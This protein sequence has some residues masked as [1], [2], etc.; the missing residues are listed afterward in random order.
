MTII[1]T[2]A[3]FYEMLAEAEQSSPQACAVSSFETV[4][5]Y[6]E[7]LGSGYCRRIEL[8]NG[9]LLEIF[10]YQL[11][12]DLIHQM[13]E[14]EHPWVEYGVQLSGHEHSEYGAGTEAGQ[15]VLYSS[16]LAKGERSQYGQQHCL[17]MEVHFD[18]DQL[19]LFFASP[20]GELPAELKP[21]MKQDDWQNF[22]PYRP[23]TLE[24][25]RVAQQIL[26]C[27]YEGLKR[28]MYLQG[29][30]F[31]LGA[32]QLNPLLQQQTPAPSWQSLKPYDIERI[33]H[34]REILLANLDH[35]PSLVELARQVGISS[36][37]LER[38]F[39]Q[40]FGTTVFGYLRDRL[41]EKALQLLTESTVTVAMVAS[42][43]GYANAAK[44]AHA[45]KRRYGITP[46]Q[47]RAGVKSLKQSI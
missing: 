21:L 26:D 28:R 14:R 32:L 27:P 46:S 23:L 5:K 2:G 13:P 1:L 37:K 4:Y 29:K 24:M 9:V 10:D 25:R 7:R 30:V 36:N 16:G 11:Q 33:H 39:R 18:A 45:F 20:T 15:S 8:C 3:N 31:E 12:E 34:A 41:M 6:P 43:V 19:H 35:P 40:V 17:G 47:C 38:Q 42:A 22:Y 44:F